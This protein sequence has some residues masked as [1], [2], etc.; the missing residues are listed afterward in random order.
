MNKKLA[1]SLESMGG[2]LG[3]INPKVVITDELNSM[4]D[5]IF[6]DIADSMKLKWPTD[7]TDKK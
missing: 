2:N 1:D 4:P 6:A 7:P 3:G 5:S